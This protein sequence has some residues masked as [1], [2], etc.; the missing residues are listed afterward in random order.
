MINVSG[1]GLKV[2]IV[3]LQTFPMGFNI[4]HFA[5]SENAIEFDPIE[6]VG[7]EMLFDGELFAFDKAAPVIVSIGVIPQ[8]DDDINL[9]IL[10]TSKKG[11]V[12]WLP[13]NDITT[14]VI[15]YPDGGK[16]VL[17]N[18]TIL[19]GPIGDSVLQSG[20]KD[21]NT[22]RFAFGTVAGLQSSK[23]TIA[24]AAQAI[25]GLL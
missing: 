11:N 13:F 3:A 25:I 21:C 15:N 1:F 23:Q 18:G 19:S 2:N 22:Y 14:M 9:K 5:D 7:Y 17:S 20:R 16:V 6:P 8:T 4:E 12:N 10:L 24:T